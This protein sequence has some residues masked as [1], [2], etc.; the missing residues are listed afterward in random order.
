MIVLVQSQTNVWEGQDLVT[1][2]R[3]VTADGTDLQQADI[4]GTGGAEVTLRLIHTGSR[5]PDSAIST[6]TIDKTAVVFDALQT[7]A[8]WNLD[9]TGYN[10]RHAFDGTLVPY[11]GQFRLQYTFQADASTAFGLIVVVT[12][13]HAEAVF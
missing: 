7:D 9:S 12:D 13:F 6:T 1:M 4:S 11:A 2:A 8:Y 3:I 10:Y 5:R